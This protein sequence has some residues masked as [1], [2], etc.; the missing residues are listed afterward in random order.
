MTTPHELA[1]KR[2]ELA[3]EYSRDSELLSDILT[4]KAA[5]WMKMRE[6][7]GS[8][9]AADKAWD[10]TPLGI[11]EMKLRLKMKASEKEMSA[12]KTMLDVM[13][14]EARNLM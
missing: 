2:V 7:V 6:D 8:D 11:N 3:A 9:R 12:I 1:E 10:A 13:S 14:D 5:L 4:K